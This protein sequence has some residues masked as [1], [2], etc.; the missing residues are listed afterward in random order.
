MSTLY[1][2]QPQ[3]MVSNIYVIN[4]HLHMLLYLSQSITSFTSYGGIIKSINTFGIFQK[5][6]ICKQRLIYFKQCLTN[7][8]YDITNYTKWILHSKQQKSCGDCEKYILFK[9]CYRPI[10]PLF[11]CDGLRG[12]EAWFCTFRRSPQRPSWGPQQPCWTPEQPLWTAQQ[13]E[14]WQEW[15]WGKRILKCFLMPDACKMGFQRQYEMKGILFKTNSITIFQKSKDNYSLY[16]AADS[17]H[18]SNYHADGSYKN[19]AHGSKYGS[20]H[21]NTHGSYGNGNS[22]HNAAGHSGGYHPNSYNN[23]HGSKSAQWV[24]MKRL[25]KIFGSQA[26][27]GSLCILNFCDEVYVCIAGFYHKK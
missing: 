10:P 26:D 12:C 16:K 13:G 19:G 15:L 8:H 21:G 20:A 7:I 4:Y 24:D 17:H 11:I 27:V 23:A 14:L 25:G 9:F 5:I 22:Y 18:G 3:T 2:I 1:W 6:S